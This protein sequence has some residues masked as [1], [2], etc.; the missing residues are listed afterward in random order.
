MAIDHP[1]QGGKGKIPVSDRGE[2]L[3]QLSPP[4]PV[5][6]TADITMEKRFV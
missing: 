1:E 6:L 5:A 2:H 3:L 4:A